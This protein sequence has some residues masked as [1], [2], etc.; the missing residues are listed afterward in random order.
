[1]EIL[2][3]QNRLRDFLRDLHKHIDRFLNGKQLHE[4]MPPHDELGG[5][6]AGSLGGDQPRISTKTAVQA[7][8]HMFIVYALRTSDV[9]A[10][11]PT[12]YSTLA[13]NYLA[14]DHIMAPY[15]YHTSR[16]ISIPT[17]QAMSYAP[18]IHRILQD[19]KRGFKVH[20]GTHVILPT[21]LPQTQLPWCDDALEGRLMGDPCIATAERCP[22]AVRCLGDRWCAYIPI[23]GNLSERWYNVKWSLG[24]FGCSRECVGYLCPVVKIKR[25]KGSTFFYSCPVRI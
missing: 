2:V 20:V 10:F 24:G 3:P 6:A 21:D 8:G 15:A 13:M 17:S 16:K 1:M 4:K 5:S 22:R 23:T 25:A 18:S 11:L 9:V 14:H 19:I 12:R 7:K